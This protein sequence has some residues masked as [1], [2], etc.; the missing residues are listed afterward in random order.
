MDD[1]PAL[2]RAVEQAPFLV[3]FAVRWLTYGTL[4][5]AVNAF[6]PGAWILGQVS[7]AAPLALPLMLLSAA[8]S[9]VVTF[10]FLFVFQVSLIVGPR[11]LAN[12]VLGRYHQ[13]QPEERFFLFVDIAGST[14]LAE[15]IGPVTVHRFL[16]HVFRLSSDPIAD[17]GGE[18]Y[19]YVGDEMV[20]TW[21][22]AAGRAD[23]QP[24]A[25]FFSIVAALDAAVQE[26][27][28]EFGVALR[29]RGALHAGSVVTGEI[30]D[31]KRDIV[32]HGD[33]MNTAARLEQATRDLDRNFLVSADAV[34][35]LT[36]LERYALKPQGPHVLRGRAASV[37]LYAVSSPH[38]SP[39][40]TSSR[41]PDVRSL[42]A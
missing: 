24:I 30:G 2:G 10:A 13:P 33:V 9:F 25:C 8:F 16:A 27:R 12:V 14:T 40:S 29:V 6:S 31:S 19:Q 4:I 11:N 17:H 41:R 7:L 18:I 32:F 22:G 20:V 26:F 37:D 34:S 38:G 5:A 36:G 39:D 1:G 23:A 28:G 42:P 35:R 15:R 21:T 3:T